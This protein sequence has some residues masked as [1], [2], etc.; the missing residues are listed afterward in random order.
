MGSFVGKVGRLRRCRRRRRRRRRQR[1]R[2]T[3]FWKQKKNLS[4]D[5][6]GIEENYCFRR[7]LNRTVSLSEQGID[8]FIGAIGT[9]C[10]IGWLVVNRS[11]FELLKPLFAF[12]VCSFAQLRT[13]QHHGCFTMCL[14]STSPNAAFLNQQHAKVL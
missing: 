5:S 9:N 4:G 1:R 10:S 14:E 8:F 7:P 12:L 6:A 3:A 13:Q 11:T 2:P